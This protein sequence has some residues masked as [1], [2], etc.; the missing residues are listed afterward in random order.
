MLPVLCGPC[1]ATLAQHAYC[2]RSLTNVS[3]YAAQPGS[4]QPALL[5]SKPQE[6]H[7]E[8]EWPEIKPQCLVCCELQI[9]LA[10]A[11]TL[12]GTSQGNLQ[13]HMQRTFSAQPEGVPGSSR[14]RCLGGASA[15]RRWMC[16]CR[17]PNSASLSCGRATAG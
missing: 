11:N 1:I 5:M 15:L 10:H 17:R 13:L 6:L 16:V 2:S 12:C 7:L 3:E 9:A 8:Q 4:V 14:G